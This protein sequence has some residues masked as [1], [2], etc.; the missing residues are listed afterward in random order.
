MCVRREVVWM[1]II[2]SNAWAARQ[3]RAA[4]SISLFIPKPTFTHLQAQLFI[5]FA[6]SFFAIIFYFAVRI[7]AALLT[8]AKM[9]GAGG[10]I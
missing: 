5:I 8:R 3:G 4:F 2:S 1:H 10:L 6:L 7:T 9:S